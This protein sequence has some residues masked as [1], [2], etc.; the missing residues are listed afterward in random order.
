MLE[1]GEAGRQKVEE[2]FTW[3]HVVDQMLPYLEPAA[4]GE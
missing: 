2:P 1:M 3:E 4:A